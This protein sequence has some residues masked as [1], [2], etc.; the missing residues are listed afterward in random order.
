MFCVANPHS[1]CLCQGAMAPWWEEGG[2]WWGPM[3]AVDPPPSSMLGHCSLQGVHE[4]R[5]QKLL[6]STQSMAVPIVHVQN[7]EGL[8]EPRVCQE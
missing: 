5:T 6:G 4:V 3:C 1:E 8:M 2:D 7:G